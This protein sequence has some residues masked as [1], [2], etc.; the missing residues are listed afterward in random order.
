MSLV[1]ILLTG[2]LAMAG[3]WAEPE[4]VIVKDNLMLTRSTHDN[5]SDDKRIGNSHIVNSDKTNHRSGWKVCYIGTSDPN[6]FSGFVES[7]LEKELFG[8][9]TY[10]L[11]LSR[12]HT[13]DTDDYRKKREKNELENTIRSINGLDEIPLDLTY[14]DRVF[15][16]V[17]TNTGQ[18]GYLACYNLPPLQTDIPD[19]LTIYLIK[20]GEGIESTH[21]L[22][23]EGG[24]PQ[25]HEKEFEVE[26]KAPFDPYLRRGGEELAFL[27]ENPS[28]LKL[29]LISNN[30]LL[31]L[32]SEQ[33]TDIALDG[34]TLPEQSYSVIGEAIFEIP[35]VFQMLPEYQVI[36]RD[37]QGEVSS[38]YNVNNVDGKLS[39]VEGELNRKNCF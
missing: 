7:E 16:I 31:V 8:D 1:T 35:S 36:A 3:V 15:P 26:N 20:K 14:V 17:E 33:A 25:V 10:T 13:Y 11:S 12:E 38:I 24:V 5:P 34:S 18:N 39:L 29:C 28:S 23:V 21:T 4:A 27:D 32:E 22:Y 19:T 2:Q 30:G 6:N 37:R 9:G